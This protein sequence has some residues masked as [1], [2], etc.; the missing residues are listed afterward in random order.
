MGLDLPHG[1][2]LTHGFMTDS[3]RISATS[4]YFESMPYRLNEATGLIDY[5]KL[6]E[7]ARLFRPRLIIAG[8]SAYSR[9]YD[10]QRMREVNSCVGENQANQG[11]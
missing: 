1:G 3:K 7:T 4:I 9:L 6:E 11:P 5:D 10:Y 8:A 2:H